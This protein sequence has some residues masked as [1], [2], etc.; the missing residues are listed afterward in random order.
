MCSPSTSKSFPS[1]KQ[2]ALCQ[3][4]DILSSELQKVRQDIL[5]YE[6]V[7][8]VLR[9][10]LIHIAQGAR[11]VE[12]MQSDLPKNHPRNYKSR[13]G[14]HQVSRSSRLTKPVE[15]AATHFTLNTFNKFD[16]LTSKMIS[17]FQLSHSKLESGKLN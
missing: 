9:E 2:S 12:S 5:S 15:V 16:Y 7:I 3:S 13:D 10:E 8:Q 6:K 4:C 11:Q 17:I 14:W 1:C